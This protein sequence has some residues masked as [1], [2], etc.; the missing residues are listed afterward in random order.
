[1]IWFNYMYDQ[2][3][4]HH[5]QSYR[6]SN[7]TGVLKKDETSVSLSST[8]DI[9]TFDQNCHHLSSTSERGKDLSNNTQIRVIERMGPEI[10]TKMLKKMTEF[11]CNDTKKVEWIFVQ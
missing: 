9:I 8:S 10:C 2:L 7:V 1:M 11:L 4:Q 5:Y 3:E 6:K